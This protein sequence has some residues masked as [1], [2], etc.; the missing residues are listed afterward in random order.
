MGHSPPESLASDAEG[1][2]AVSAPSVF[3]EMSGV[4]KRFGGVLAVDKVSL[5]IDPG[6]AVGLIGPNGA[7]KTTLFNLITGVERP[8]AGSIWLGEKA[9][10]GRKPHLV[11]RLGVGRTFQTVRVFDRLSVLHNLQVADLYVHSS[12]GEFLS[13]ASDLLRFVGLE[14]HAQLPAGTLSY[15]QRKLL[16]LAM[17]LMHE[18]SLLLLDEP[19]AGVNPELVRKIGELVAS[20]VADGLT[21]LIV[22]H[23]VPFVVN[24]CPKVFVM[25]QGKLILEGPADTIQEDQRVIEAYL[26]GS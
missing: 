4:S 21:V 18:P 22:E 19:V 12:R 9:I 24:S 11:S 26:G 25:S 23:N 16:E 15:G 14:D 8:D 10:T 7:G 2:R 20:L 6:Q 5:S 1:D 17:A 3:L 13:R